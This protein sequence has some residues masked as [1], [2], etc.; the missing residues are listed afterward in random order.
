MT[1]CGHEMLL[2]SNYILYS[3]V[4]DFSS[5]ALLTWSPLC[6]VSKFTTSVL[7]FVEMKSIT[8][9]I[10]HKVVESRD[11]RSTTGKACLGLCCSPAT[12]GEQL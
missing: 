11:W 2:M 6:C 4:K 12:L 5:L 1:A 8:A 9:N 10:A 3:D 7:R